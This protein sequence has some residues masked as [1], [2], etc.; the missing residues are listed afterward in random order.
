MSYFARVYADLIT[1]EKKTVEDVPEALREEVRQIL[2][3][4]TEDESSD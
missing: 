3:A 2:A 1:K 4:D